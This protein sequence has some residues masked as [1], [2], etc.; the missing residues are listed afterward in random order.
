MPLQKLFDFF[1]LISGE[2]PH[3]SERGAQPAPG[4]RAGRAVE[5]AAPS[6]LGCS[7]PS[8]HPH[9][10]AA[11]LC[12]WAL[13]HRA[14]SLP[15]SEAPCIQPLFLRFLNVLVDGPAVLTPRYPERPLT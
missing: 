3:A 13:R 6:A 5:T 7:A 4:C 9:S 10:G 8:R 14:F 1:G 15:V 12:L 2:S 11:N